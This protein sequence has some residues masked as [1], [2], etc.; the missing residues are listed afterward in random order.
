M[1][2]RISSSVVQQLPVTAS[3]RTDAFD[4]PSRAQ[5]VKMVSDGGLGGGEFGCDFAAA[6]GGF[7]AEEREDS[8]GNRN[9]VRRC[10]G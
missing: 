10:S 4:L 8:V 7:P 3:V 1:A 5:L 6:G 9:R 2:L